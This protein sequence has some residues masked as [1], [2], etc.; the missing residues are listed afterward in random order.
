MGMMT[1]LALTISSCRL[2]RRREDAVRRFHE[3]VS[4]VVKWR[5]LNV[6]AK[7]ESALLY[8][9]F[10]RRNQAR[11][12]PGQHGVNMGS[13]WG[14]R[15]VSLRSTCGQP[16]VNLHRPTVGRASDEDVPLR[17]GVISQRV[18]ARPAGASSRPL[19]ISTSAIF[20]TKTTQYSTKALKLS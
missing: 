1:W 6:K 14:Q 18:V 8:L 12:T 17:F 5:K 15:G 16:G 20:V 7:F 19:L 3:S 13:T 4:T 2:L 11:S 9:S 10:K